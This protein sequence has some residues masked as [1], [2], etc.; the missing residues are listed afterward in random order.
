MLCKFYNLH[1]PAAVILCARCEF[2]CFCG[3]CFLTTDG[4]KEARTQR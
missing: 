3:Y 2:L 1:N 4:A